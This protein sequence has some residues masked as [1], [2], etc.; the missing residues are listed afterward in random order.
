MRLRRLLRGGHCDWNPKFVQKKCLGFTYSCVDHQWCR[1]GFFTKKSPEFRKWFLSTSL[2]LLSQTY[3]LISFKSPFLDWVCR[4]YTNLWTNLTIHFCHNVRRSASGEVLVCVCCV[5]VCM[6]LYVVLTPV[7][8][9]SWSW[10]D[11]PPRS[12]PHMRSSLCTTQMSSVT[13][14]NVPGEKSQG[15]P[16]TY[17]PTVK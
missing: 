6:Y 3:D 4:Y 1:R 7:F 5:Y 17:P 8:S 16:I 14:S 11:F 15:I 13:L 10:L 2:W 9:L 12:R